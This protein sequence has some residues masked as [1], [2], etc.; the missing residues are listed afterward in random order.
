MSAEEATKSNPIRS[1]D[2]CRFW[3]GIAK[4]IQTIIFSIKFL[5]INRELGRDLGL[6]VRCR[7]KVRD[8]MGM[9]DVKSVNGRKSVIV[10]L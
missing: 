8:V 7:W 5:K 4:K 2:D 10:G 1:R 3:K 9:I 6:G